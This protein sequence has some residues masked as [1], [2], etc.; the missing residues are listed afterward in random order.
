MGGA[1]APA[2]AT[3]RCR[4]R[5]CAHRRGAMHVTHIRGH[6]RQ[7]MA[8]NLQTAMKRTLRFS[9]NKGS[10]PHKQSA[11]IFSFVGVLCVSKLR[12]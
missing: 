4:T 9:E 5:Y 11:R 8:E 12:T 2:H 7:N 6:S 3:S 1:N 10:F